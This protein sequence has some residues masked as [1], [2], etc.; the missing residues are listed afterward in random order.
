MRTQPAEYADAGR[1]R[2]I[3]TT[4]QCIFLAGYWLDGR[5]QAAPGTS[6]S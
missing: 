5:R 1:W 3:R 4:R 2:R 6:V